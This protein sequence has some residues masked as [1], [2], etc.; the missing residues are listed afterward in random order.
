MSDEVQPQAP[1][2]IRQKIKQVAFRHL[3]RHLKAELAEIPSRCQYNT[4]LLNAP[5]PIC[6]CRADWTGEGVENPGCCDDKHTPDQAKGCPCYVPEVSKED[7]K[8]GFEDFL[9]R[10]PIQEIDRRYPDIAALLWALG[11]ETPGRKIP[12]ADWDPG[13]HMEVVVHGVTVTVEPPS[14]ATL[15][16][17]Y[18][19]DAERGSRGL[20]T[21]AEGAEH[22]QEKAEKEAAKWHA[23]ADLAKGEREKA[24]KRNGELLAELQNLRAEAESNRPQLPAPTGIRGIFWRW[25][26]GGEQNG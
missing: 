5:E 4:P 17:T 23:E 7:L 2:A 13:T 22:R 25:L 24:L 11:D 9:A 16:E 6:F 18:L 15:L 10:A 26:T 19:S 21:R 12:V 8:A 14:N 1:G 3:K 20:R